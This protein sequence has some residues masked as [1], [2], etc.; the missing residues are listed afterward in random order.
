MVWS[1]SAKDGRRS[2]VTCH[3]YESLLLLAG[4]S[5]GDVQAL[6]PRRPMDSVAAVSGLCCSGRGLRCHRHSQHTASATTK[7]H[8]DI[9]LR[10]E[11]AVE[12]AASC[13]LGG[14]G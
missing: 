7:V 12:V 13:Q 9:E 2:A 14:A 4:D 5:T 3:V 11:E 6:G 8:S 10:P 1:W